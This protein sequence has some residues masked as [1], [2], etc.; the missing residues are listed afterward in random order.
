MHASLIYSIHNLYISLSA[1]SLRFSYF[2]IIYMLHTRLQRL[3]ITLHEQHNIRRSI[4]YCLRVLD[5]P[6]T[7][8]SQNSYGTK[9]GSET[10]VLSCRR[11]AM[12]GSS[13]EFR[14]TF[15]GRKRTFFIFHKQ[16]TQGPRL[17][18][19]PD[20]HAQL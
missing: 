18:S 8:V 19:A 13:H 11:H 17:S 10:S 14:S 1:A 2:C 15:C 3:R 20:T 7:P 16:P 5:V 9:G 6:P 4:L 12:I